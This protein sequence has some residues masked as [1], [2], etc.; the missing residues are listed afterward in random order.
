[1]ARCFVTRRLP[2]SALER[3]AAAHEI[4]VWAGESPPDRAEVVAHAREADGLLS[5]LTERVDADLLD[6][7]P[8]LVAVANYAVGYDNIDVE[9]ATARGV[10]VGNTPD[11]LT[12]ATAD[13]TWALMLAAAR[14][15]PEG[16]RAVRSGTWSWEPDFLLGQDVYGATLG[17]VGMGRIGRAVAQRGSG[18]EM[19]VI[20]HSRSGGVPLDELLARADYV[21]LH[22]PLT[23]ETRGLIGERELRLMKDSAILVNTARGP[24]VHTDALVRALQDG[25]IAGA[26]L[27][28][29]DPEPLPPGHRL[30][31][32]PRLAI[33]PHIGSATHTARAAMADRAVDNLLAALRG[34]RMPYCVN[35]EVYER[36]LRS[37]PQAP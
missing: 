20:H 26:G 17:I 15:L 36:G 8:R 4:D 24:L 2:G 16:E 29:T 21:S 28:V 31:S 27:D 25:W 32:C 23:P 6:R 9:A 5:Q 30:L 1:M 3:L 35:P 7:C 37:I 10:A 34:E 19:E 22:A 18:F 12:D 14:R 11:V 13:L 33:A